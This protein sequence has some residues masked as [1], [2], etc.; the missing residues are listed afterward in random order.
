MHGTTIVSPILMRPPKEPI[1]YV[2]KCIFIDAFI[3]TDYLQLVVEHESPRRGRVYFEILKP[4][5]RTSPSAC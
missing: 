4:T 3:D 2:H 1:L 5:G